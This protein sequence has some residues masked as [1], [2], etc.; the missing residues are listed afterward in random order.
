MGFFFAFFFLPIYCQMYC[1]TLAPKTKLC[2]FAVGD[3]I[4]VYYK[5]SP[6]TF[7]LFFNPKLILI[8]FEVFTYIK[9]LKFEACFYF[10]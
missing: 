4:T 10:L 1:K 3:S 9:L 8:Y 6:K 7:I 2:A 5:K